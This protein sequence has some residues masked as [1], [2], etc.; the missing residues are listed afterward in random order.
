[1]ANYAVV[2]P[3][4]NNNGHCPFDRHNDLRQSNDGCKA[5]VAE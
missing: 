1:M 2:R 4:C 5:P 3:K